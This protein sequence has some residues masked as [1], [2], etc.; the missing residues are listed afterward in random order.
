MKAFLGLLM[1]LGGVVLGFYV[2]FWICFIGGIVDI[3]NAFKASE[4][5]AVSI[6]GWGILKI[7]F[8]TIAGWVSALALIIPGVGILFSKKASVHY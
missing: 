7:F 1:I 2:G 5:V 3:I 6:I 4:P 8:A